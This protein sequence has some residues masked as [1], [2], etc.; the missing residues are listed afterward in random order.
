VS[1]GGDA[2]RDVHR[3]LDWAASKH[4]EMLRIF[5]TFLKPGGGAERPCGIKW[6]VQD[7]PKGLVVARFIVDEPMPD[8]MTMLAA[9]LVHNT[10]S[11]LD[12]VLARLKEYLGG[13]PGNGSFPTRQR[14]DLWQAHVIKPGKKSPL[15]GLPQGA[16]DLIYDEQPL[17]RAVPRRG[18]PSDLERARQHRQA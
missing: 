5:E 16:V 7:R 15:H 14:E 4:D 18:P 11:A 12:H 6:R 1:S 3:K 8:A 13:D 17:H 9:D 2:L 10:R